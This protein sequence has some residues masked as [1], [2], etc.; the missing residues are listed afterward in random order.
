MSA[1]QAFAA[2]R[3]KAEVALGSFESEEGRRLA[4]KCQEHGLTIEAEAED[5]SG[6]LPFN[7]ISKHLL[8]I[9]DDLLSKRVEEEALARGVPVKH[10]EA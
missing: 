7:E 2:L 3:G 4:Q 1:Q 8:I 5:R 6:Y 9:E 10:I